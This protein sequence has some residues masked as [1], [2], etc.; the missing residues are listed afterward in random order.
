M[1]KSRGNTV[2]PDSVLEKYGADTLRLFILF[3]APPEDQLEWNAGGL[4]GSWKFLNRVYN[5]VENRF[6]AVGSSGDMDAEDKNLERERHT[7][8]KKV[9]LAFDE[10]YKFNTAISFIM[11]LANAIDKYQPKGAATPYKQKL[12]ND[13]IET[14]VRLLSPF[15]P[16][17]CEELWQTMGHKESIA[18]ISWPEYS[19]KS[20]QQDAVTIAVQ[21]NGKVRGQFEVAPN[22]TEEQLRPVILADERIQS[23]IAGKEIKKFIVVPNKLVSIVI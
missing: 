23:W 16:H 2:D 1:S 14:I 5:M 7:A 19:E 10:G 15:A 11:V 22:A 12:L 20:L 13:A 21:V 6:H 17:M 9:S 8:I 3:A 18:K 4:E